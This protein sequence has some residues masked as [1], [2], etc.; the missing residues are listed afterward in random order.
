MKT[1]FLL[2]PVIVLFSCSESTSKE[3]NSYSSSYEEVNNEFSYAGMDEID[4]N[5]VNLIDEKAIEKYFNDG[6]NEKDLESL[7]QNIYNLLNSSTKN[8]QINFD[9]AIEASKD[10]TGALMEL[11]IRK[12]KQFAG[13][14]IDKIVGLAKDKNSIISEADISE[15]NHTGESFVNLLFEIEEKE[16]NFKNTGR[17]ENKEAITNSLMQNFE[18]LRTV[19][20]K[21]K[22]NFEE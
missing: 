10:K 5:I 9:K 20:M 11:K 2:I 14:L 12:G 18:R 8:N 15:I 4:E 21:S 1:Y 17:I 19:I 22:A 16:K 13:N 6:L 7:K 3:D